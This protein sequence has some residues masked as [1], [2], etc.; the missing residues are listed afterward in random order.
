MQTKINNTGY[1]RKTSEVIFT[2]ILKGIEESI[3]GLED[4]RKEMENPVKANVK[5]KDIR[6]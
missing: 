2:S 5:H 3:S 4:K 1:Q 6:A